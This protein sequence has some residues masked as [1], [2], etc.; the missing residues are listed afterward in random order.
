MNRATANSGA[1]EYSSVRIVTSAV[2][3]GLEQ[4]EIPIQ[5]VDLKTGLSQT[6][7]KKCWAILPGGESTLIYPAHLVLIHC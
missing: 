4:R 7:V 6:A 5:E 1:P 2:D 3:P